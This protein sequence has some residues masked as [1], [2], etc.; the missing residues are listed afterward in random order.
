MIR[1]SLI[2]LTALAGLATAAVAAPKKGD[3]AG[4]PA[5]VAFVDMQRALLEVEDGKQAKAQ[6]EKMKEERQ[7][8]LDAQ[9][10]ALRQ[11][12]KNLEAQAKFMKEDVRKAKEEEFREKLGQLQLTYAKLQKELAVEEQKLTKDILARMSRILAA[13]GEE[14]GYSMI[15]EKTESSILWAP[16]YLDLTN[17]LI[18][19]YN[20]G[21]G[22]EKA[23][24]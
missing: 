3:N 6:L 19:R 21:E 11:L 2:A 18:R 24:K 9:Q 5:K 10:E 22:R 12:Q 20:D 7:K 14:G 15:F 17:E 1:T 13:M 4:K 8:E 16:R 23:N